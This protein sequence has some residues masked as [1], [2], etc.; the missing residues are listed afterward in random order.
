MS[1]LFATASAA[2]TSDTNKKVGSYQV[3]KPDIPTDYIC[4]DCKAPP[5][6]A[7]ALVARGPSGPSVIERFESANTGA[8][9][10]IGAL[11]LLVGLG[12]LVSY[13]RR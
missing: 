6:P 13:R 5:P 10:Q 2:M 4:A 11:L 1:S 12:V 7:G 3:Q 9:A 8:P